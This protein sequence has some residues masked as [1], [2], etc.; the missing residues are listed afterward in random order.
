MHI[1]PIL[2][3]FAYWFLPEEVAVWSGLKE[4][5]SDYANE[6]ACKKEVATGELNGGR[7]ERG[8]WHRAV[9]FPRQREPSVL[10]S[11][12]TERVSAGAKETVSK[13]CTFWNTS[14]TTCSN[15]DPWSWLMFACSLGVLELAQESEIRDQGGI[16]ASYTWR[17][18]LAQ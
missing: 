8:S 10:C 13:Y 14:S 11:A 7:V 6:C 2:I 4:E 12:S 16:I 3:Y 18:S 15:S 5:Y 1:V 17:S 9:K